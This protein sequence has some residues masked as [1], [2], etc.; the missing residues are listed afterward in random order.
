VDGIDSAICDEDCRH[1]QSAVRPV[2]GPSGGLLN[3]VNKAKK[4]RTRLAGFTEL[5]RQGFMQGQGNPVNFPQLL[6]FFPNS[7]NHR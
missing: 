7:I 6:M 4:Q 5:L 2:L 3:L 1:P